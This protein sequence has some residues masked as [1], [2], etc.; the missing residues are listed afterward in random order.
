[1]TTHDTPEMH[2]HIPEYP[3]ACEG[4]EHVYA[5]LP[6]SERARLPWED[7]THDT[8]EAAAM[9]VERMLIAW[10]R[11][12]DFLRD[13]LISSGRSDVNINAVLREMNSAF[14][15]AALDGCALV[16][17]AVM[18]RAATVIISATPAL[19][20][21]SRNSPNAEALRLNLLL[22]E[23]ANDSYHALRAALAP[24]EP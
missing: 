8:P 23:A 22:E 2:V 11:T 24:S 20:R 7:A 6:R 13:R 10:R 17:R 1:M 14:N 15:D 16:P 19:A 5:A 21:T 9:S 12:K 18:E 3:S 4:C